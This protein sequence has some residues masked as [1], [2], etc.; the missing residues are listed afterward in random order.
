MQKDRPPFED[1]WK[2]KKRRETFLYKVEEE[3]MNMTKR[4]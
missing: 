4:R 2:E 3:V 1:K